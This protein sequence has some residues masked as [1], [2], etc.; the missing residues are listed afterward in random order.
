M[1]GPRKQKQDTQD[2]KTKEKTEYTPQQVYDCEIFEL[3]IR[4]FDI[5]SEWRYSFDRQREYMRRDIFKG[6]LNPEKISQRLMEG[7]H[8]KF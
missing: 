6:N 8:M 3:T 5:Q 7:K 2:L 1:A 4:D